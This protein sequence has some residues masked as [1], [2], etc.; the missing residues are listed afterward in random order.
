M[1][2]PLNERDRRYAA[3]RAEMEARGIDVLLIVGRDGS[4]ERG[5]H[6]YLTD[7]GIVAA[8][9][10]FMI[11]AR[12]K[13]VEPMVFSPSPAARRGTGGGGWLTDVRPNYRPDD[14]IS[15][16]IHRLRNGGSVGITDS[17]PIRL[18]RRLVEELGAD[19]I[20]DAPSCL[21]AIRLAK[22]PVEIECARRSAV[23]ADE[24]YARLEKMVALGMTD[25]EIYAEARRVMHAGGAEYSMDIIDMGD[26]V[27]AGPVGNVLAENAVLHIE[28]SPAVEGY[29]T[30]LRFAIPAKRE[31]WGKE[32][33]EVRKGWELAFSTARK[34]LRPGVKARD[35]YAEVA[36]A[37]RGA[38]YQIGGRIGHGVGLNVDEFMSFDPG[39]DSE[40][41]S[42]AIVVIHP[43]VQH[44]KRFLMMGGTFLVTDG[45]AE[46]LNKS[47]FG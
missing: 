40:I 26:G 8:Y 4:D 14:E 25:F 37:V 29:F 31:A 34:A 43:R 1:A 15:K 44:E 45:G 7:Y 12:D 39:D 13:A 46:P 35:V 2:L 18:Y 19:T 22:S 28:L 5:N 9:P 17:V 32:L 38:G 30:Q 11:F 6:R 36:T 33:A 10:H 42:G 23:I 16:E 41:P 21:R 27:A 3:V 47:P 20:L 24:T